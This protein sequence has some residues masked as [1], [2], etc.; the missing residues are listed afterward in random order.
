MEHYFD[1]NVPISIEEAQKKLYEN[2]CTRWSE[3]AGNYPKLRTYCIFKTS[4]S[5]E[6]YV[7]NILNRGHRST[8]AEL[9]SGILPLQIETGRYQQIPENFRLCMFCN[10]QVVEDEKHFLFD[11]TLYN[12]VRL[13]FVKGLTEKYPLF[14]ELDVTE[15]LNVIMKED[16]IAL[17]AKFCWEAMQTCRRILYK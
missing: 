6:P 17:I 7:K 4:F 14:S 15:K 3:S 16:V 2:M 5:T 8:I 1:L 11:C 13:K 10:D 9:R 12:T